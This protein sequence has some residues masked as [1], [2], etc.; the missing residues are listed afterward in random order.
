MSAQQ[1]VEAMWQAADLAR[2]YLTQDRAR[3]TACPTGM[4]ADQLERVLAWAVI[5]QDEVFEQPGEPPM[6]LRL[7]DAVAA[8]EPA[9]TEFAETAAVRRVAAGEVG[10]TRAVANLA[11]AVQTHAITICTAVTR[12]EAHGRL[13]A[14]ELVDAQTRKYEQMGY[15]RPY[16]LPLIIECQGCSTN[17]NQ[18]D[19]ELRRQTH[20]SG[21]PSPRR[22]CGLDLPPEADTTTG[23]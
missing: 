22:H 10:F 19:L 13:R 18:S 5:R 15:P 9:D 8:L 2:S 20:L 21:S 3:I 16:T 12:L 11:L 14:L 7:I 1:L 4:E 6:S 23:D 17:P